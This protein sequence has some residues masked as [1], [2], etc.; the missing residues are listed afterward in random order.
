LTAFQVANTGA[1]VVTSK[2]E[3][4]IVYQTDGIECGCLAHVNG[5]PVCSH[6][7]LYHHLRGV[8]NIDPEPTPPAAP[9]AVATVSPYLCA[10]CEDAGAVRVPNRIRPDLTYRKPCPDCR[11]SVPMMTFGLTMP[12]T[13]ACRECDG[14]GTGLDDSGRFTDCGDCRGPGIVPRAVPAL[15]WTAIPLAAD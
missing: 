7:A 14:T 13:R 3:P 2:S 10:T 6:R 12:T 11:A 5:D 4:G 1:I 8:L 9:A 15:D